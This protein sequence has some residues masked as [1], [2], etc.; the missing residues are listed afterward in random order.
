[1]NVHQNIASAPDA[2]A[3]VAKTLGLGTTQR[4]RWLSWR[5]A[6]LAALAVAI[7]FG[8]YLYIGAGSSPS[9]RYTTEPARRG[10]LTQTVT[11]TGTVEPT[12]SVEISSELSGTVKV[13]HADFN[14]KVVAGQVLAE[15]DTD[16]L[17]AEV[18]HASATLAVN[19][20]QQQQAEA[21]LAEA[22]QA[23]QR[24]SA[25]TE[26][27]Y[28]SQATRE[29]AEAVYQRAVAGVA[30]AKAQV[31]VAAAD[32]VTAETNLRK[33]TIR[34]PINGVVMSRTVEPGQTVAA[35]LQ[36][37]VL[38]TIAENLAS[39][40]LEV[41]VDEADVGSVQVGQS[42][43]FTVEAYRDRSFPAKLT[44]VRFAPVTVNN[45]VTYTAVLSLDNSE[46]LL[47][48]G[49]TATAE[50]VVNHVEDALLV[51]NAALR[52]APPAA[53]TTS[54]GSSRS[55]I[56]MLLPRRSRDGGVPKVEQTA[57]GMRSVYVL[58]N[59]A[60]KA[61]AVRVGASDG[62]WT[63]VLEGSLTPVAPVI[64]D[65]SSAS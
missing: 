32:L 6:L 46:L 28:A 19:G 22:A 58:E 36:A 17:V 65:S 15:L 5:N 50:I 33:A 25:L 8:I 14:D 27:R 21:T 61:V 45:V 3:D 2:A 35:S 7:I 48:P 31:A 40:Q 55:I 37:P 26:K 13:V 42:A 18:S 10:A 16:K 63:E 43:T 39:M 54:G 62:A 47:R 29:S 38:F 9:V 64:V 60:P 23:N 56:S 57:N 12:N 59:G 11:A 34:S 44:M 30:V 20:A 1:M 41:A 52:F 24:A 53:T 51:P 4:R 49:M